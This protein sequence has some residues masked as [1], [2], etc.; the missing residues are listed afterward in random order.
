MRNKFSHYLQ[1]INI[2]V[3]EQPVS[4]QRMKNLYIKKMNVG[5]IF[6]DMAKAFD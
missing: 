5:G 4:S 3:T 1:N 6:Y 2:L